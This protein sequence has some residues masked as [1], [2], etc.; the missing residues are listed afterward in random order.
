MNNR[1]KCINCGKEYS[2]PQPGTYMCDCG[3]TFNF[4]PR[5]PVTKANYTLTMP[6]Y[7][8]SSSRS[9]KKHVRFYQP[10]H[11][12]KVPV[13]D[14]PLAKISLILAFISIPFF[15]LTAIPAL[16][17]GIGSRYMISNPRYRYTGDG[18]AVAGIILSTLSIVT[19]GLWCLAKF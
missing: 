3:A 13:T 18:I 11:I 1:Y 19:W 16:L 4:P 17:F 6:S 10:V 8:D 9:V 5:N 15:G 14:C 7:T 12:R 2:I